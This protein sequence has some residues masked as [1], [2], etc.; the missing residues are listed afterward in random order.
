MLV[1][2]RRDGGAVVMAEGVVVT[3]SEI[4]SDFVRLTLCA[5]NEHDLR[6]RYPQSQQVS[7]DEDSWHE[8]P[9]VVTLTLHHTE[10]EERRLRKGVWTRGSARG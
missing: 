3:V 6:R 8:R 10:S 2:S 1:L 7:G 4:G 5:P 9:V